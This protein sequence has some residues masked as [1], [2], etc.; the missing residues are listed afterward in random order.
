MG[1]RARIARYFAPL[2]APEA[3]S[4]SLTDDAALLTLPA[5]HALVV[6]TDSVIQSVHV[7]AEATPQHFAQKLMR[8][9]LSDLAAMGATPWRYTL[10]LHTPNG[11]PDD[12]FAEFAASLEAEQ[13]RFNMVLIGGDSTSAPNAPI[14]ATMTCFGLIQG[15]HLSRSGAKAGDDVYVSGSIGDAALGLFILQKKLGGSETLV[16]RYH[17]PEPRLGLGVALRGIATAA[18][19]V[20]D[21]LLS[22]AAQLCAASK[23]GAHLDRTAIPLSPSAAALLKQ[24]PELLSLALDGGDDYELC[25]T[26]PAS[27]REAIMRLASE[28]KVPV[29]RIGVVTEE[30]QMLLTDAAGNPLPLP[31]L[32][33]EHR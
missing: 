2:A 24:H 7:L 27:A 5:D 21:G 20:S 9:N 19:D 1:E 15:T 13:K 25:F 28:L 33:Y 11:L 32:G 6:T 22:D 16:T 10:N 30:K 17:L 29:T 4:L 8:R 26:A 14:H 23:V 12:W 18:I 3:G 31:D